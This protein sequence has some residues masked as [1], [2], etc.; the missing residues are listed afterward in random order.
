M[1]SLAFL[2]FCSKNAENT[3]RVDNSGL[4]CR[5]HQYYTAANDGVISKLGHKSFRQP[6]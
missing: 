1:A 4:I 6:S 2:Q 5:T 3:E